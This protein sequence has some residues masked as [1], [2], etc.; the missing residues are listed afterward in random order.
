M[1]GQD[2]LTIRVETPF[3]NHNGENKTN[4]E[5]N[6]DTNTNTKN[7]SFANF[8]LVQ[9]GKKIGYGVASRVG[10]Y[11]GSYVNQNR[12]NAGIGAIGTVFSLATNPYMAI[13]Q[14]AIT[15]GF[16]IADDV[17]STKKAKGET[18][19]IKEMVG[20]STTNSRKRGI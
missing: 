3:I 10:D 11:T 8:S 20:I 17:I 4:T 5:G 6:V 16:A 15:T 14:I 1:M 9:I 2:G 12:I 7:N 19:Y 13:A 18:D